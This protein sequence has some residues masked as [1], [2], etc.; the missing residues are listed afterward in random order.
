VEALNDIR[1]LVA[2]GSPDG[3]RSIRSLL[4]SAGGFNVVAEA[5]DGAEAVAAA[6][7]LR[8]DVAV[9]EARLPGVDGVAA[10][11]EI[12]RHTDTAV[13]LV[14]ESGDQEDLRRAMSAGARDY[15]VKPLGAADLA[16]A[17]RAACRRPGAA[18]E[19]GRLL[20]VLGAKGGAGR[21]LVAVNLAVAAALRW[22][23]RGTALVDLDL[24]GGDAATL[25]GLTPQ[26]SIADV[27]RGRGP[28]DR[29]LL[30]EVVETPEGLP[31]RLLASPGDP[32]KAAEVRGEHGTWPA[33]E[34]V[35][36]IMEAL[37]DE[38]G[39]VVVDTAVGMAEQTLPALDR[40]D[41]AALVTTPEVPA[42]RRTAALLHLITEGLGFPRD[43][44]RLVVNRTAPH[45][46][47]SPPVV[48][49]TVGLP[50]AVDLP[51]VREAAETVNA[52]RPLAAQRRRNRLGDLS[53]A[54]AAS[55]LGA[56]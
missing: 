13:I 40:A 29:R 32:A 5:A 9:V 38:F 31:I 14:A 3:R 50:V 6:R 21:S 22:P 15:L 52:G 2:D 12:R 47:L 53:V 54:L 42:L 45:Q 4:E 48:A 49:E 17:V 7:S 37:V 43:R 24:E 23:E 11:A 55:L 19:R 34:R 27:L 51:F 39:L 8:P 30:R 36:E 10:A 35:G 44:V 16:R 1:V 25:C 20:V 18:D 33:E 28:L 26:G 46:E 41:A 56:A